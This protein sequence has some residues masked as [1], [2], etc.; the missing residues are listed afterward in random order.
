MGVDSLGVELYRGLMS[1]GRLPFRLYC[2]IDGVG[3]MWDRYRERGPEIDAFDGKLTIR[4]LKMYVDGA[5]GSRGAALILPYADAPDQRGLTVTAGEILRAAA[6]QCAARGFQLCVHAIGDRANAI[7]LT[8]FENTFTDNGLS[9]PDLRFRIEHAQVLD[10]GDIARFHR[11]GIIPSMQPV[12]CTSDMPWAQ[13][14]LGPE[15]VRFAYAWRS[16]L[17]Q[18]N[19]IPAGSDAPVESPNPVLGF[20]AAV[21]RQ[22]VQGDPPGGWFPE[23][24]MTRDEALRSFTLWAA[25]AAFQEKVKGSIEEGKWADLTILS[26]DIMKVP[27]GR[28]PQT[29]VV[30]TMIGGAVVY[31]TG[32]VF[33]PIPETVA[34]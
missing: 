11:A 14:R 25:R 1:E 17:D 26:E 2:A 10:P 15:R 16:L 7:A 23:Q 18:Q 3:P 20:Y 5:L 28:I 29:S 19:E 6:Q 9:G 32:L 13:E 24:R 30:A 27:A 21:T 31:S 8:V 33:P 12:H 22:N 34:Q 4:A